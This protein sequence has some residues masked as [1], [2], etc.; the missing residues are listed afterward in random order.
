[1]DPSNPRPQTRPSSN[2]G[3]GMGIEGV[4]KWVLSALAVTTIWHL[5]AALVLFATYVDDSERA[6]Q[7]GLS[8]IAA[9]FG[10]LGVAAGL[11]IHKRSPASPWLLFGLLPGVVGL[12]LVLR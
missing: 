5:A 9:I 1:M 10:M 8:V 12:W 3:E 2:S 11:A 7:I 6:S 4:Q